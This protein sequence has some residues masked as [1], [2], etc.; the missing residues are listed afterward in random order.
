MKDQS[1]DV[2]FTDINMPGMSG[3]EFISELKQLKRSE[4]IIAISGG[5]IEDSF[6]RGEI[7]DITSLVDAHLEK[8]FKAIDVSKTIARILV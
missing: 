1:F 4:K 5:N 7:L 6:T 8:P 3:L 2:V